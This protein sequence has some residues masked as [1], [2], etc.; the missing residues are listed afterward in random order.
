MDGFA[1]YSKLKSAVS[2]GS[3]GDVLQL[4]S[5]GRGENDDEELHVYMC[6]A[7]DLPKRP[8]VC[9]GCE[10]LLLLAIQQGN[11]RKTAWRLRRLLEYGAYPSAEICATG[12]PYN[13]HALRR[14]NAPCS[15]AHWMTSDSC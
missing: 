5:S 11:T 9:S 14:L 6:A 7:A 4:L 1:I 13:H 8:A 10:S 12:Y 3:D 15:L 2:S